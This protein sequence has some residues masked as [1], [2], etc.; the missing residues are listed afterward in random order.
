MSFKLKIGI[1]TT[2]QIHSKLNRLDTLRNQ[3]RVTNTPYTS[4]THNM[5]IVTKIKPKIVIFTAVKKRCMLHGH[6]LVMS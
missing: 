6:V 1:F 5:K 2:V 4:L 3:V